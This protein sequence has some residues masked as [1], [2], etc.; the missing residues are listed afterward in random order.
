MLDR[1]E[2]NP[3]STLPDNISLQSKRVTLLSVNNC[4]YIYGH[5]ATTKRGLIDWAEGAVLAIV[6]DTYSVRVYEVPESR[7]AEVERPGVR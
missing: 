7:W 2:P 6:H 3:L 1:S 4:Q 5:S